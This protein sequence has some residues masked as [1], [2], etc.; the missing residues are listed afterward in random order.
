MSITVERQTVRLKPIVDIQV[1]DIVPA[2]DGGYTR[3]VRFYGAGGSQDRPVLEV[4]VEGAA[5]ED[6]SFT[7]PEIDF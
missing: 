5:R 7:T 1:T 3:A 4:I 2:E 6:V